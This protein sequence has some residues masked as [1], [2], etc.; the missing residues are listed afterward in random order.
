VTLTPEFGDSE[1]GGMFGS[2][3]G[4]GSSI[5]RDKL[6]DASFDRIP[7]SAADFEPDAKVK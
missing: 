2:G 1:F 7:G 4:S 3:G 6:A 5:N